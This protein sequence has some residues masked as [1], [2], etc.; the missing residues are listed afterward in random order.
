MWF[1]VKSPLLGIEHDEPLLAARLNFRPL[2]P[3]LAQQGDAQNMH[4]RFD[5]VH[6]NGSV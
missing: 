4:G 2:Q 6:R 5:D 3:Q 1:T